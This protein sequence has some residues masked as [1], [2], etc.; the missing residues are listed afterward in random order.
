M[1][2]VIT[3]DGPSVRAT[4]KRYEWE[5]SATD[6]RFV[7]RDLKSRVIMA[8]PLQPAIVVKDV[9]GGEASLW[10][11][12]TPVLRRIEGNV[13]TVRYEGVNGSARIDVTCRFDDDGLWLQPLSYK[14]ERPED[15]VSV[16]YFA[17]PTTTVAPHPAL[18]S[19][20]YVIPGMSMSPGVSPLVLD[21]TKLN[22]T[23]PLG[24]GAL[25]GPGLMQE[26]GLPAHFFCGFRRNGQRNGA[27]SLTAQ[28]SDAFCC[29]LAE[30]PQ[31]DML[32][33]VQG[34]HASPMVNLR[35]D[36][37][38]HVRGP[39]TLSVG[40]AFF[41]TVGS[42]YYEAIR[43]YYRGLLTRGII[44]SK[45]TASSARKNEVTLAPQFNTWGAQVARGL[46]PD[47]FDEVALLQIYDEYRASGMEARMFVVD[48]KWEGDYGTLEHSEERFP[49][50]EATLQRFRDDGHLIGLWAAF[51]RCDDPTAL[52]LTIDHM[53]SRPD[54]TH[55]QLE[56]VTWDA[57]SPV[58]SYESQHPGKP[59]QLDGRFWDFPSTI[60]VD[61]KDR[62]SYYLFDLS[63]PEVQVALSDAARRFVRRYRPDMVK[64][65]FGYELPPLDTAAPKDRSWAGERLLKK[66]LEVIITAM[67][68]ENPDLVVMYYG[69][70]PL[71]IDH[72]DLHS[73]DDLCFSMGDYDLEANR[74]ISFS[75]LCGEFGI[76][77]YGSSGYDW[78][79]ASSIWFDSVAAGTIGSLHS[80]VGDEIDSR[81]RPELI[82]RY[83]G[84]THAIRSST[85]FSIQHL[86][87]NYSSAARGVTSSSWARIE[88]EQVVLVALR[89]HRMDGRRGSGSYPGVA[90][91]DATVV[92]ASRDDRSIDVSTEL[93]VVPF[94]DGELR[95]PRRDAGALV[96]TVTE[97]FGGGGERQQRAAL[98][99]GEFRIPLRVLGSDGEPVEWLHISVGS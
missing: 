44:Q 2:T 55:L 41:V 76:P 35:S 30:L 82:A 58:D 19:T 85:R 9:G 98:T 47:D 87:A 69:L 52:G 24:S 10:V 67:K 11:A 59:L 62:W 16:T 75:S 96:A 32:L 12:G 17:D 74:R 95:L 99:D 68:E 83:N 49:N 15:V 48:A 6:D 28:L 91:T 20:Y 27:S 43:T 18:H 89:E 93:A 23:I 13:V 77:T 5:W 81:P 39:G 36:L 53:L 22:L 42:T 50:F 25:H 97:H 57:I 31:G 94:G 54:G 33:R 84:L 40:P 7:L 1:T 92:V 37:W 71:L 70:S 3:E 26:W 60:G 65:D 86:D 34:G 63:Q 90:S 80:F 38:G 8:G 29:G 45:A 56:G 78:E 61:Q 46:A 72:Y 88:E 79:T 66:G 14:T 73:I 64:F 21:E 4:S 51:L